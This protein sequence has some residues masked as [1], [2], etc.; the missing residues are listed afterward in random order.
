VIFSYV[1]TESVD[2]TSFWIIWKIEM[3][4]KRGIAMTLRTIMR[5][6]YS[7]VKFRCI[8]CNVALM[9]FIQLKINLSICLPVSFCVCVLVD[10]YYFGFPIFNDWDEQTNGRT[11]R[12]TA[13]PNNVYPSIRERVV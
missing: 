4:I 2:D 12:R 3:H 7:K 11:N 1:N 13:I 9:R 8:K 5:L 6:V 10:I